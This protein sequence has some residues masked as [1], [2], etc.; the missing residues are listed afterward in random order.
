MAAD[1]LEAKQHAHQLLEK[2]EPS[3]IAAVVQLLEVL[4]HD[5]DDGLTE[6]DRRAVSASPSTFGWVARGCRWTKWPPTW[7]SP[8]T[9]SAALKAAKP[10]EENSHSS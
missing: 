2:L 5:E 1:S 4:V 3:Q 7:A 6:E 8:W 10:L 9:R